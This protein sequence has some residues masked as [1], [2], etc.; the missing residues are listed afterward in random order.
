[1]K[2][3]SSISAV[4]LFCFLG[5]LGI[6]S[7]SPPPPY[8]FTWFPS[9]D[10]FQ[11]WD[12]V[13]DHAELGVFL[14][15]GPAAP[16]VGDLHSSILNLVDPGAS[17]KNPA[18]PPQLWELAVCSA[19]DPERKIRL[20]YPAPIYQH[21]N[22][23]DGH[24][25]LFWVGWNGP[26]PD[27]AHL[28]KLG[29]LGDGTFLCALLAD[30]IRCSNVVKI[31]IRS[32][33]DPIREPV[34]RVA[35]IQPLRGQEIQKVGVWIVPPLPQDRHLTNFAAANTQL[36]INGNS[37]G[38]MMAWDG[39]TYP[40]SPGISVPQII[41]W[42]AFRPPPSNLDKVHAR[43]KLVDQDATYSS[44]ETELLNDGTTDRFDRIFAP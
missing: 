32:D 1:M 6:G 9:D 25:H 33:Y 41:L 3:G 37:Y 26:F 15:P 18:P 21:G 22:L 38:G 43:A 27:P 2:K 14:P 24:S 13:G 30:G 23:A 19:A 44:E 42:N 17:E 31:T 40:L 11:K 36:E 35:A 8:S 34:L 39:P 5:F 29:A 16:Q 4:F 20:P 28:Q 10:C 12:A 7:A